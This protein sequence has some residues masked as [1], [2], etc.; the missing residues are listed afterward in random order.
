MQRERASDSGM[1]VGAAWRH[2]SGESVQRVQRVHE[3][4]HLLSGED[5]TLLIR[6]DSLLILHTAG[7]KCERKQNMQRRAGERWMERSR[8][9]RRN[10]AQQQQCRPRGRTWIFCFTASIES[11]DSTSLHSH[12]HNHMRTSSHSE[13]TPSAAAAARTS[14][15]EGAT[16]SRSRPPSHAAVARSSS[17]R[18]TV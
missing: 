14:R 3:D 8:A 15:E 18:R 4:G 12:S 11:E 7:D 10:L 13:A 5:E 9:G 1:R 2:R 17:S 6:R 16:P